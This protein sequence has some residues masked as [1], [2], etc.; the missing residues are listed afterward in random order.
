MEHDYQRSLSLAD[1]MRDEVMVAYEM[2]DKPLEPHH[3]VLKLVSLRLSY[4]RLSTA[5]GCSR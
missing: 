1:A 3:G 2:N 5:V 4:S